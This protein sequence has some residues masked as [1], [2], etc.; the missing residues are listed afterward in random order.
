MNIQAE[1]GLVSL[2]T[3]PAALSCLI[4]RSICSSVH[5]S[6]YGRAGRA[7]SQAAAKKTLAVAVAIDSLRGFRVSSA[8]LL[9]V[10]GRYCHAQSQLS[11]SERDRLV[12]LAATH[13][14]VEQQA[15]GGAVLK[16]SVA[17]AGSQSQSPSPSPSAP[18]PAPSRSN[19]LAGVW[20]GA[21]G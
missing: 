17:V 12:R 5:P 14:A 18:A 4:R 1:F 13:R 9:P 7:S 10:L 2:T 20:A 19:R 11:F 21:G 8:C 15:C 16:P 3:P 6:A